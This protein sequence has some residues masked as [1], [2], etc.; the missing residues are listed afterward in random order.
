[1]LRGYKAAQERLARAER[2]LEEL[3]TPVYDPRPAQLTGMPRAPRSRPGSAQEQLADATLDLRR[4]YMHQI[5]RM[6]SIAA[7]IERALDKLEPPVLADVLRLRFLD[8]LSVRQTAETLHYS[9]GRIYQL[10]REAV[11][12][13]LGRGQ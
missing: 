4:E 11:R 3:E 2:R 13:M 6:R 9:K 5:A 8:G 7:E 10:Q 12:E 1:M